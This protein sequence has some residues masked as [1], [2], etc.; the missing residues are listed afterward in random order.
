MYL[1]ED[2]AQGFNLSEAPL[3]RLALFRRSEQSHSFIW[4]FSHLLLDEICSVDLRGARVN[5]AFGTAI[6]FWAP[7]PWTTLAMYLL[8]SHL[9]WRVIEQWPSDPSVL[10]RPVD[11]PRMP[12]RLLSELL[13]L[14]PDAVQDRIR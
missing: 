2:R 5:K 4:S 8:L 3:M 7:S 11:P 6:K 13:L 1:R 14:L 12:T 10:A 9:S